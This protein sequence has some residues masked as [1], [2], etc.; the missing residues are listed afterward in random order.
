MVCIQADNIVSRLVAK[1]FTPITRSMRKA[2]KLLGP[3]IKDRLQKENEYGREWSGKPVRISIVKKS[4]HSFNVQNDL[5]SWLL[6]MADGGERRTVRDLTNRV[7]AMN[8]AAIHT[9]SMVCT[10][11]A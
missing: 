8:F 6:E 10:T 3:I 4:F 11:L 5:L 2:E 9:T 7:L 1:F